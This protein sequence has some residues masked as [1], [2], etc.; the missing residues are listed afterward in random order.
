V[1]GRIMRR[2]LR[3]PA[4][5]DSGNA[6]VEFIFLGVLLL[7]PLI[8]LVVALSAVQRNT[9]GVTQAAREAGRTFAR[10]GDAGAARYAAELALRDQHV[11]TSDL[12]LAA[13][14]GG[15]TCT[16]AQGLSPELLEPGAVFE[17]CVIRTM[18]IPGIP[19]F[20]DARRNTVTGKFVV[21]VDDYAARTP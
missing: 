18:T 13:V 21:H 14:P 1:P 7:V 10:T 20:L 3:R 5:D 19:S 17:L 11:S 6:M 16:G 4:G 12:R 8:Y 2:R 9:Y 15:G